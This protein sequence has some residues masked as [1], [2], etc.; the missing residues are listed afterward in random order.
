MADS[1]TQITNM[2]DFQKAF[3]PA[4]AFPLD[5]RSMFGTKTAADAAAASAVLAGSADQSK[6]S[7]YVGQMVT[8]FENDVVTHYTI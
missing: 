4:G 7:Y 3:K 8:V 1:Y 2:L 5:A 6:S